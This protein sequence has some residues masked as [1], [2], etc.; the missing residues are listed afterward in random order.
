VIQSISFRLFSHLFP[1]SADMPQFP[2]RVIAEQ[3]MEIKLTPYTE[4]VSS[5]MLRAKLTERVEGDSYSLSGG[6]NIL[7]HGEW[8]N[9]A[10]EPMGTGWIPYG[11]DFYR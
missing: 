6:T 3:L 2:G 1:G 8:I 10:A 9:T 4:G 5:T 7:F 11:V